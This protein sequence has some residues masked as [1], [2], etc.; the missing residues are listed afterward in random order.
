[1]IRGAP[2]VV[3]WP[4]S[5]LVMLLFGKPKLTVLKILKKSARIVKRTFSVIGIRLITE[6]STLLNAGP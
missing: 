4:N 2:A 1:M 3:D 6:K 5:E